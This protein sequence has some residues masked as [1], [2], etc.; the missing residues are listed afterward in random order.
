MIQVMVFYLEFKSNSMKQIT[1][2]NHTHQWIVETRSNSMK[3][4][5]QPV[6]I[7]ILIK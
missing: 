4:D 1:A 7:Y 5:T 6:N 3:Q 2:D